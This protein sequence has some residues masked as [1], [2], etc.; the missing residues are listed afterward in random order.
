[1]AQLNL[2]SG[3]V[4]RVRLRGAG[5]DRIAGRRTRRSSWS[6][7]PRT[8]LRGSR[9][10]VRRCA[11]SRV[12]KPTPRVWM[13]P[14][15]RCRTACRRGWRR[16]RPKRARAWWTCR[17]TCGSIPPSPMRNGT[18]MPIRTRNCSTRPTACPKYTGTSC[19]G[20]R[21]GRRA[22]LL[23]DDDAA[24]PLPAAQGWRARTWPAGHRGRQVR[25][26]G[27]GARSQAA[28]D[29]RR[30]LWQLLALQ[31]RSRRIGT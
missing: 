6:S 20:A 4:W 27:R 25:R 18:G 13:R 3:R 15:W 2:Q 7:P 10:L 30:G 23:P 11:T 12:K 29:V 16:V 21:D 24:R 8:P 31:P 17:L 14:F 22:G 9:C 28:P 5:P 19:I 1:M 26:V